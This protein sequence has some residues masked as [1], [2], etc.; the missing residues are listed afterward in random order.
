MAEMA[1][2]F[3]NGQ[4]ALTV[5]RRE[6]STLASLEKLEVEVPNARV[7]VELGATPERLRNRRCRLQTAVVRVDQARLDKLLAPDALAL[8]GITELRLSFGDGHVLARG[9]AAAGGRRAEFT[10][11]VFFAPAA[12]RRVRVTVE[13]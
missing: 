12:A 1:L 11:R 5:G 7:P 13:D 6:L 10:A 3:V 2:S 9:R 8:A 4:A